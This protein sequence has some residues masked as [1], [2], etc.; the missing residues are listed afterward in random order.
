MLNMSHEIRT[1]MNA[2]IG[3]TNLLQKKELDVESGGFVKTI[4]QSSETLLAIIN[5]V[6]DLSK[7][8]AGMMRIDSYPFQP[9]RTFSVGDHYVQSQV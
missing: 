8:E 3:F 4:Q 9:F 5:D 7:I 1:P 2:I 6:L